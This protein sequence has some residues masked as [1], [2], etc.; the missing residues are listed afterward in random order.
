MSQAD[1]DEILSFAVAHTKKQIEKLGSFL[2]F[3]AAIDASGELHCYAGETRERDG[4]AGK[5]LAL[6]LDGLAKSIS[7]GKDRAA[8]VCSHVLVTRPDTGVQAD[9]VKFTLDDTDGEAMDCYLPFRRTGQGYVY[10]EMF[11]IPCGTPL[12]RKLP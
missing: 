6:L 7:D 4:N 5:I 10:R 2:P 11:A 8:G 12:F 9:A 3:V 1:R